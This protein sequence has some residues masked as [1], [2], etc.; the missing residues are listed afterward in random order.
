MTEDVEKEEKTGGLRE[1][2]RKVTLGWLLAGFVAVLVLGG[3][4][5]APLSLSRAAV[6][7]DAKAT[8]F[9]LSAVPLV[10]SCAD[11]EGKGSFV[12]C[13]AAEMS[14]AEP[15]IRWEDGL[16]P[17]GL[18]KEGVGRIFV[19]DLDRRSFRVET[20]SATGKVFKYDFENGRVTRATI[21]AGSW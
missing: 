6:G 15:G 8:E 19:S 18:G 10:R 21:G 3:G 13:D 9:L 20:T 5:V 17:V 7:Q 4:L 16:A 11:F 1:R 2:V 14:R 12:G